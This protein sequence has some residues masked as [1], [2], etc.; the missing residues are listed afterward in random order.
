MWIDQSLVW[1]WPEISEEEEGLQVTPRWKE[2]ARFRMSAWAQ[3]ADPHLHLVSP[4][5]RR[6]YTMLGPGCQAGRK[7]G[8]A[9][10]GVS[11]QHCPKQARSS[12]QLVFLG[13]RVPLRTVV[14]TQPSGKP[15]RQ[16]PPVTFSRLPEPIMRL[17]CCAANRY[18]VGGR[19]INQSAALLEVR[20]HLKS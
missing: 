9:D 18:L 12:F 19:N 8:T 4:A 5:R 11:N 20:K 13:P 10:G 1:C 2:I 6:S 3:Q 16:A 17:D 15:T 14:T 7:L